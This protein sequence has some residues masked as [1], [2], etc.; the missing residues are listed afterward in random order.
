MLTSL[1]TEA[2]VD[3]KTARSWIGTLENSFII[4]LLR[5]HFNKKNRIIIKRPKLYFYDTGIMY[6]LKGI[7]ESDQLRYHLLRGRLYESSIAPIYSKKRQI[8]VVPTAFIIGEINQGNK[9]M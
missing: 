7:T 4:Y 2:W 8:K 1:G 9:L 5:P 3:S 6:S